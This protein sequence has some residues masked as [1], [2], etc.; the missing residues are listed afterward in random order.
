V[1]RDPDRV[2]AV[3][4]PYLGAAIGEIARRFGWAPQHDIDGAVA[5]IWADPDFSTELRQKYGLP[6]QAAGERRQ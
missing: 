2:R 3:D 6:P 5:D 1:E 4:R